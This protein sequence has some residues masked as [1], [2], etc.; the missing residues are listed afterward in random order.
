MRADRPPHLG[1]LLD[2]SGVEEEPTVPLEG[3]P[4]AVDVRHAAAREEA[5]EDLR[6]DRVQARVHVLGE[7]RAR[8]E[9]QQ[10]R[11]IRAQAVADLD[12]AVRPADPDVDVDPERVVSP[13]DVPQQLVP[14]A[15]VR[16]VDDALFLPGAPGMG[17]RAAELDAEV[18]GQLAQLGAPLRHER[19]GLGEGLAA[20]GPDLDFGRDQLT[21]DVRLEVRSLGG[22]L[23]L[24][25]AVR[26][27]ERVRIEDR[28]L[29]LDRDREVG[30]VSYCSRPTRSCSSPL[31]TLSSA[32]ARG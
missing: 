5:R 21:D 20:A 26:E 6:A 23:Q 3:G 31:R 24:L 19:R 22:S 11:E 8:G 10:L 17:S 12:G 9:R 4:V 32:T 15:V 7:R 27:R 29:L 13:D 28:E 14:Q 18:V 1:V 2:R 16:R 25:E 30:R